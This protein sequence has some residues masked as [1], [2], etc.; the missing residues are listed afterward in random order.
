MKLGHKIKKGAQASAKVS[1]KLFKKKE[2]TE[3]EDTDR[4]VEGGDQE[5]VE[6]EKVFS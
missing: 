6:E 3:S 4:E 1:K 2:K 5:E